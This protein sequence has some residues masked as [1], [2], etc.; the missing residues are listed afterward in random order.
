[1]RLC[2]TAVHFDHSNKHLSSL[3]E[4]SS[5]EEQHLYLYLYGI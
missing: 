1:M 3:E 4:V 5:P 2:P